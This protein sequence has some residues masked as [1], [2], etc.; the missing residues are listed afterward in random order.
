M[1]RCSPRRAGARRRRARRAARRLA[2]APDRRGR[3]SAADDGAEDPR[4]SL[5]ARRHHRHSRR[6]PARPHAG[7]GGRAARLECH[8]FCPDPRF[9]RLR[10]GAPLRP[11]ADYAD[12]AALD[13]FAADVDVVTYEFE[14][15][16][17]E[18]ATFLAARKPVLPDPR[19][20]RRR[21]TGWS[22][23]SSSA[24]RH[25]ARRRFAAVD[26]PRG[27][28]CRRWRDRPAGGAQD[29]ALRL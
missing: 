25:R 6:R 20:S 12:T 19:C 4:P 27:A 10:R 26:S 7:A 9:A 11:C 15:V 23:S 13:R 2:R 24:P 21:R 5:G 14:N 16:P 8:V 1:R 28:R 22:K 29:A 18:T 3:R 17:A